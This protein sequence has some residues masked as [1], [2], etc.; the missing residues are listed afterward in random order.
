MGFRGSKPGERRGG[1][2]KG[3]QNKTTTMIKDAIIQAGTNAGNGDLVEYLTEQAKKNPTAFMTLL[4]KVLPLQVNADIGVEVEKRS[5]EIHIVESDGNGGIKRR[6]LH[7]HPTPATKT[8]DQAGNGVKRPVP[9]SIKAV[10]PDTGELK[11]NFLAG[12]S[13]P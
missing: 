6:P 13:G 11:V 5:V 2:Q 12:N 3:T 8:G 10:R 7:E 9:M 1:R 4:G